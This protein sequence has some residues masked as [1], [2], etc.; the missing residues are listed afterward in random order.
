METNG[1][2]I[3]EIPFTLAWKNKNYQEISLIKG[4]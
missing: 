3:E 1:K 2:K 4:I